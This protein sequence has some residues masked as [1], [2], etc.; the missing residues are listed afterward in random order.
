MLLYHGSKAGINQPIRPISRSKCDFG[1]GFYMGT[2]RSQPLT[3]IC[4]YPNAK[5]YTLDLDT[6][7]LEILHMQPD[8]DWALLVAYNRGKL[9]PAEQT[10]LYTRIASLAN[11]K[12]IVAGP[13]ANDR[14]FVVLDRFFNG[15]ITDIA[16]VSSLSALKLGDQY[17]A[18]TQ[19]ACDRITILSEEA[20]TA[21]QRDELARKSEANRQTGIS[22][23]ERICREHR[24]EGRFFDEILEAGERL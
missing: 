13:I 11:G 9:Q 6:N 22:L 8:L 18:L 10:P 24:R 17:V 19:R 7:D 14:M 15:D 20:L 2:E 21:Q 3:L 1:R 16:L 23:A 12:D 4:T 5:L